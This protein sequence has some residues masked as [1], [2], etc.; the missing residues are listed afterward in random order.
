MRIATL[1]SEKRSLEI[2]LEDSQRSCANLD[3]KYKEM[4]DEEETKI[5]VEAH[6]SMIEEC[7]R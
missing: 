6:L 7:R 4:V 5:N 2:E 3:Q 1:E